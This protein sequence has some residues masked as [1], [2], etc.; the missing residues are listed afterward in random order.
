MSATDAIVIGAGANGLVAAAALGRAGLRVQL[1]ERSD[2]I[3]GLGRLEEFA[4]GF[5]ATPLALDRGWVP[6]M[7]GRGLGLDGLEVAEQASPVTVVLAPGESLTLSRD[8]GRAAEAIRRYSAADAAKWPA[9]TAQLRK[10]AGFLEALYQVPAPDIDSTALGEVLTMLGLARRF[11]ALGRRDMTEF[12][13]MMPMSVQELLDDAFESAPLKAA[14]AAGGVQDHRQ[15]PRSGGTAFALLHHL[16]GAAPG[17]VRGRGAWRNGPDAFTRAAEDAARR[18]GVTIRT[19]A[20]VARI[21]V[22]DDAAAGVVLS[23]GEEIAATRVLSTADPARTLLD[24]VDPVWLDPEFLHAVRQIRFRGC[25]ATVLYALDDLPELPGL[26]STAALGGMVTLT[27]NV[28]ALERAADAAKYGS[29]SSKLHVELTVPTLHWPALAPAGKHVLVARA[30]A[31]PYHLRD[32]AVWD[33][34]GR[35]AVA[36]QVTSAIEAAAPCFTSRVLGR[37]ALTPRDIEERY[38][39]T[40]GAVTHGEIAL[41]Q[42]LFMRPVAGWGH[43]AMP[44]SGLYLGGAGTHPGPGILGGPGWL[45]AERM[46]RD[47]KR[48]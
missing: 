10:L 36:D 3:G 44:I 8:V 30:Q 38:G 31:V 20:A 40:E 23:S 33:T 16:T 7:V 12:L 35:D 34:A 15:G 48:G 22:R 6:P 26:A 9:F 41:D 37:V 19:G 46:L 25:T 45:A 13:R 42:I 21:Q 29:I 24:W 5:R 32:G 11:R 18:Y 14:V 28:E 27:P 39:L 47:R 2:A 1:L 43:Y 17:S 4:P